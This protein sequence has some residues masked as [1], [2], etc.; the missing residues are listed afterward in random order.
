MHIN[1]VSS[2]ELKAEIKSKLSLFVSAEK[3]EPPQI[4]LNLKKMLL[5]L[6]KNSQWNVLNLNNFSLMKW[7]FFSSKL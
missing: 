6:A 3:G 5:I 2:T 4:L 1:W 7:I